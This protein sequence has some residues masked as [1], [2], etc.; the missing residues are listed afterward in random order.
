[1]W[2]S[3]HTHSHIHTNTHTD[4][5]SWNSLP[6]LLSKNV[7]TWAIYCCIASYSQNE[8]LK[9]KTFIMFTQGLKMGILEELGW[10]VLT[11]DLSWDSSLT[12]SAG[13]ESPESLTTA[14][15]S[16]TKGANSRGC[17]QEASVSHR[18]LSSQH[19]SSFLWASSRS[20]REQEGK[21]Q[22]T[23]LFRTHS[24]KSNRTYSPF[25]AQ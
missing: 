6:S 8:Q 3:I 20:H 21:Q 10:L 23:V 25:S 17:G 14:G 9:P 2:F 12:T 19:D 18:G 7:I 16:T 5:V 22:A 4:H 13:P 24:L 11:Q 1:M 15:G